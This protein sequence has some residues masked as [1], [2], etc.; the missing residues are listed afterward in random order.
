AQDLNRWVHPALRKGVLDRIDADGLART[1]GWASGAGSDGPRA[2]SGVQLAAPALSAL[3]REV[4]AIIDKASAGETLRETEVTRLFLARGAEFNAVCTAADRLRVAVNGKE[5]S[6]VVNRNIN[7]D[8]VCYF[9]CRFCAFSK[10]KL[11]ENLRGL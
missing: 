8:N 3:D 5:V 6:Y 7:Y 1:D 4:R 11:S 2:T 9:H 10:G